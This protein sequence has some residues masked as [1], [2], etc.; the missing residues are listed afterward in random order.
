[1]GVRIDPDKWQMGQEIAILGAL[2]DVSLVRENTLW[3]KPKA[4]RIC[5]LSAEVDNVVKQ[6]CLSSSRAARI[7]GKFGFVTAQLYGKVGRAAVTSLRQLQYSQKGDSSLTK[8]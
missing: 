4:S 3:V 8:I 6:N 5:D 7:V 1:M 2:V